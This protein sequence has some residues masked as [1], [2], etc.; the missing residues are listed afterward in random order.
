MLGAVISKLQNWKITF[1]F[2]WF[3]TNVCSKHVLNVKRI[4][5]ESNIKPNL[6]KEGSME[7]LETQYAGERERE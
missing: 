6:E 1:P 4:A 3:C 5:C 2:C 7:S